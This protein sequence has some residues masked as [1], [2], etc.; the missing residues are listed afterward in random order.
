MPEGEVARERDLEDERPRGWRRVRGRA[1]A[2]APP[3]AQ[4]TCAG[5]TTGDVRSGTPKGVVAGGA[6]K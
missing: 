1:E 6:E 3:K 2:A 4:G 5:R